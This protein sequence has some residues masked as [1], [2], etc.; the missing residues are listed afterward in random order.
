[1]LTCKEQVK[2]NLQKGKGEKKVDL[3]EVTADGATTPE[4]LDKMKILSGYPSRRAKKTN[5]VTSKHDHEWLEKDNHRWVN[6][7]G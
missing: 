6:G 1:M 3:Q 4:E 7:K 5:G 2:P